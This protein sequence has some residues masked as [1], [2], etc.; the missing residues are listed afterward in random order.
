MS[1]CR[2]HQPPNQLLLAG[3]ASMVSLS[4]LLRVGVLVGDLGAVDINLKR[5]DFVMLNPANCTCWSSRLQ[6]PRETRQRFKLHH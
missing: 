6:S 1:P 3:V 2:T 4:V 5:V